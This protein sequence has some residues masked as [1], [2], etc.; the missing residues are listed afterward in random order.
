MP[1]GVVVTRLFADSHCVGARPDAFRSLLARVARKL[2]RRSKRA[3]V[4]V[5]IYHGAE[6]LETIAGAQVVEVAFPGN[7]LALELLKANPDAKI[8]RL[9]VLPSDE[10]SDSPFVA[11]YEK[12]SLELAGAPAQYLEWNEVR[13]KTPPA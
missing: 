11:F 9:R 10:G 1:D 5:E 2:T 12:A 4:G 7:D 3:P 8:I 6:D 13:F